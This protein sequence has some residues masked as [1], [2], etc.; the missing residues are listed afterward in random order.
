[1]D[2]ETSYK[3]YIRLFE[4]ISSKLKNEDSEFVFNTRMAAFKK[5]KD[6]GLPDHNHENYKYAGIAEILSE[7]YE[8]SLESRQALVDLNQFFECEVK[9]LDTHVILLSNGEY[10]QNNKPIE[11]INENVIICS[12]KEAK[13]KHKEIFEK[14]YNKTVSESNDSYAALNAMFAN[15]GLFIYIPDNTKVNKTIQLVNLTHGFGNKNVFKRN[16]VVVG[17]NAELSLIICDHTLNN[18]KNFTIDITESYIEENGYLQYHTLQNEPNKSSVIN[19]LFIQLERYARINSFVLSLHGGIIR[20]NLYAKLSGENSEANLYGVNLTDRKQRI[21]NFTIIDHISPNCTSNELYKGILDEEAKGSFAGRI[22]VRP[23]AQK[24]NAYQT[25]KNICLT[26]EAKMRTKPQLEIYADDVKCSHGA[27]VGQLD[28]D[29]LF[30]LRQRGIDYK[31]A[32]LLLMFA[33]VNDILLKMEIE[34]LRNRVAS[35]IN[36][37]L[38]GEFSDCSHCLLNCHT[39]E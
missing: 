11:G 23:G 36:A 26:P 15:D 17:K 21:D 14:Y 30:Y 4:E 20:N 9:D 39:R 24:T 25:N 22:I 34:P 19:N 2:I 27:T 5:F 16:L 29:A 32:R 10:Y 3:K 28:E 38:R 37:R 12:L 35:L 6:A 18:S 13:F 31:E 8:F 7:D 1:M 33:F